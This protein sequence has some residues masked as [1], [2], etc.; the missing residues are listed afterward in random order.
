[1]PLGNLDR[2]IIIQN[3]TTSKDLYGEPIKTWSNYKS[4]WA[5]KIQDAPGDESIINNQKVGKENINWRIRYNTWIT[6]KMR[7][8]YKSEYYEIEGIQEE[9]RGRYCVLKT[10]KV[11]G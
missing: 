9:G 4:V 8:S 1:M 5:E 6:N 10:F 3:Y 2:Y 11:D 7:I